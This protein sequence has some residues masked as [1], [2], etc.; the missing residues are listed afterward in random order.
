MTPFQDQDKPQTTFRERVHAVVHMIPFGK[1]A[2]YGQVAALAGRAR[3]ARGAGQVL[4]NAIGAEE[5]PWHRVINA[6]GRVSP[7]L[8]IHRPLIQQKMLEAEGIVFRP[9]GRC[10]MNLY[11]WDGPEDALDWE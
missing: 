7:G 9:S 8:D 4:R 2:T 3:A 6:Q 1:V 5:L 10:D 11:Q